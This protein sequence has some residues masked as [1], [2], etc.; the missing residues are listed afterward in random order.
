MI[1]FN[2]LKLTEGMDPIEQSA[3]D[4]AAAS[5]EKT[6]D[7]RR[8]ARQKTQMAQQTGQKTKSNVVYASEAVDRVKAYNRQKSDWRT[9][10]EEE[11]EVDPQHP[12]V[13][14][15]P[16]TN[17]SEKEAKQQMK[18][19]KKIG[20]SNTNK[21]M[22]SG[23]MGEEIDFD[24]VFGDLVEKELSIADQMK[25]S[26]AYNRKSPEEKKKT[27]QKAVANIPVSKPK[28]DKRSDAQK[29]T[30][31]AD[32]RPGSFYRNMSR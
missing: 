31:A 3:S 21:A 13:N 27:Q 24:K 11:K 28:K 2:K 19:A 26:Q 17:Q 10:L 23:M 18:L 5:K 9:E 20:V 29:M 15:M 32:D 12:Y 8:I 22:S 1:D 30:D 7:P 14:V 25:L 16:M 4:S 6:R